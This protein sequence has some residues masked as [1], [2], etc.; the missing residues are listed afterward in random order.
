MTFRKDK[1]FY[2]FAAY[3]FLK[4]LRFFEP[5]IILYFREIGFS[6][7]EIGTLYSIREITTI[8]CELPT[9]FVAD[10]YGRKR[11]MVA[12]MLAYIT[13]FLIF[14]LFPN[15]YSFSVAMV[16]FGIGE[17][18]RTGTHK[19]LILEHLRQNE[20]LDLRVDYYG[21]TR[22]AS[23]L[24]SALNAILAASLVFYT[25]SY[26]IIFPAAIIP[27]FINLINLATYP[28]A[29]DQEVRRTEKSRTLGDFLMIFRGRDSRRGILNSA[30]F[31]AFFKSSKEYLQ[32][33]L[34][35]LALALPVMMALDG[36]KR[37]ALL[38]GAV[39]FLIYL[40][41]SYA[42]RNA[43]RMSRT[44]GNKSTTLNLTYLTGAVML[45]LA[46]SSLKIEIR[47]GAVLFF[48]ILFLLQNA[49]RPVNIAYISEK[50]SHRAMASGLSVESQMKALM[51]A[52]LAP[53]IGLL[54]DRFGIGNALIATGVAMGLLLGAVYLRKEV[55]KTT[56]HHE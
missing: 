1:Q 14:Y 4:N 29:L 53:V 56:A 9:G 32:P 34:K 36:Q 35:S 21:A 37:T 27:C 2:R 45:I 25:G 13:S 40:T 16:L 33:I 41:T 49:R 19:A 11:S 54:A 51:M 17:A 43:G 47:S 42:S 22:G 55:Q 50:I 46:G 18:F 24:G 6:F 52:V 31:D 10:I 38:V 44:I 3:G 7:L 23:Q 48:L 12:S 20:M 8:L 26:R 30:L 28:K 15:F 5:F 39:Y